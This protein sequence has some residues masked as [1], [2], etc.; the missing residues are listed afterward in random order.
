MRLWLSNSLVLDQWTSLSSLSPAAAASSHTVDVPYSIKIQYKVRG[1]NSRG[2]A[3]KKTVAAVTSVVPSAELFAAYDLAWPDIP[4][5]N[6]H[7]INGGLIYNSKRSEGDA[8]R[9]ITRAHSVNSMPVETCA[10]VAQL[11]GPGLTTATASQR[12][13]FTIRSRDTYTNSRANLDQDDTYVVSVTQPGVQTVHGSVQNSG[14][15]TYSVSY[16]VTSQGSHTIYVSTPL[17]GGL[18]ATYFSAADLTSGAY[19]R[20]DDMQR[21]VYGAGDGSSTA[22][23]PGDVNE[24]MAGAA[25]S[26]RWEG[27]VR[28]ELTG[29]YRSEGGGLG[30]GCI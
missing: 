3:F 8:A 19:L 27:F 14:S 29:T 6:L 4:Y 10:S 28:P 11:N 2:I 1:S 12:A 23:W 13:M 24:P 18:H 9:F 30:E 26:V 5:D 7:P 25:F 22:E 15:G 20:V 17:S 21:R 16:E